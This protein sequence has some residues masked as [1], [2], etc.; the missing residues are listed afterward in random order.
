MAR[1]RTLFSDLKLDKD[2]KSQFK[3]G[4]LVSVHVLGK[5]RVGGP[6]TVGSHYVGSLASEVTETFRTSPLFTKRISRRQ[7]SLRK[8][9]LPDS[10]LEI[11]P[12]R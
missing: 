8:E 12:Q 4:L 2:V 6:T 5:R 11:T 1:R 7:T 10:K 9:S 3:A